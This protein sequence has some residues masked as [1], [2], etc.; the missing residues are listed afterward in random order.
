MKIEVG[1]SYRTRGGSKA[2]I[3]DHDPR[4]PFYVWDGEI[5]GRTTRWDRNGFESMP[6]R[7]SKSDLI[8]PWEDTPA[9]PKQESMMHVKEGD[10]ILIEARVE[11][12]K[13]ETIYLT[14]L[15]RG[16]G[17]WIDHEGVKSVQPAPPAVGD[18]IEWNK[19]AAVLVEG[20]GRDW[21]MVRGF[22][23]TATSQVY[24]QPLCDLSKR[25][26]FRV[27]KRARQ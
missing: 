5:D 17:T 18:T 12:V 13:T 4:Q 9:Q 20:T 21:T 25:P 11:Q 23:A 2:V 10:V 15:P 16:G 1:K 8:A 6:D 22:E 7:P 3:T 14:P 26:G 19:R 24:W 27:I